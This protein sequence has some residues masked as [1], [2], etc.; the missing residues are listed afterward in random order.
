M[1]AFVA[2]VEEF[3]ERRG[4]VVARLDQLKLELARV[5][6][7]HT[8]FQLGLHAAAQEVIGLDP[9]DIEPGPDTAAHPL[10]DGCV[11]P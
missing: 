6:H 11:D 8:H 4:R 9:V 5:R 2:G 1:G 7:G 3:R 10:V